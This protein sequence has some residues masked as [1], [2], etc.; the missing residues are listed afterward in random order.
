[1]SLL[2]FS[3][4]FYSCSSSFGVDVLLLPFIHFF[5]RKR[6]KKRKERSLKF[7]ARSFSFDALIFSVSVFLSCSQL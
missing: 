1:L 5:S 3:L 4:P 2:L 7:F 6:R